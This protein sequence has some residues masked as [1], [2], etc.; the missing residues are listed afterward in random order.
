MIAESIRPLQAEVTA[1]REELARR[2]GN[3]GRFEVSLS[4][5]PPELER[6]L[7]LRLRKYL[8]PGLLDEARQQS[9]RLLAAAKA[10]I[11]Q[12][13]TQGYEAFLLRLAEEL[14]T[15]EKQAQDISAHIS[16]NAREQ[17]RRGLDDFHQKL[18]DGGNSL[19]CLGEELLESLRQNLDAEHNARRG[20]LEQLRSSLASESTRLQD[21]IEYLDSRI[22]KL[23][24]AVSCLE[25]GLDQRLCQ[26]ASNT[27]RDARN[28][29]DRVSQDILAELTTHSAEV[30]SNQL[31]EASGSMKTIQK[32]IVTSVSESLKVQAAD[33]LRAFE[34]STEKLAKFYVERWGLS[35]TGTLNALVKS[36]S[37]QFQ[38]ETQ[39]YGKE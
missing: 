35:L 10:T 32:E 21:H 34:Q 5:I 15:V 12:Q 19:R 33:S 28:E 27:V 31:E 17:L 9:A 25:S 16:E 37:E 29:L 20:E 22:A 1:L 39:S 36:V 23:D 30:L 7:E 11:V 4:S 14:K 26:M 38:L 3:P 8:G 2:E 13:T 24:G 6:Q 18:M